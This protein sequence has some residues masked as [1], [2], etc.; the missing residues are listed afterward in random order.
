MTA[1][2]QP[3]VTPGPA[4]PY[5]LT[6]LMPASETPPPPATAA[7]P[8]KAPSWTALGAGVAIVIGSF[9]P[10]GSVTAPFVGTVTVFGTDG[11]D[12]WITAAVGALVALYGGMTLRRRFPAVLGVLAALAGLGVTGVAVWKIAEL[13]SR[14]ADTRAELAEDDEFG[15]A[16]ALADAVHAR[17]GAGLWLLVAAG[18]VAAVSIVYGL[19]R[20]R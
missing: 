19:L 7:L 15:F 2:S 5:S 11:P 9:L 8:S 6:N 14:I 17:V 12:G 18:L 10:W 13:R 4:E 20:R 3:P 16:S 1:P